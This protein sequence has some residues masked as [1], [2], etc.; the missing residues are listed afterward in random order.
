MFDEHLLLYTLEYLD[1]V[2]LIQKK[3]VSKDW[4]RLCTLTI[5]SKCHG[6]LLR[7]TSND[8]RQKQSFQSTEEIWSAV[9]KYHG[10]YGYTRE[11]TFT[12]PNPND[13]E[14]VVSTYGIIDQWDVSNITIFSHLFFHMVEF[15]EDI[16]SWDVSNAMSMQ[17]MFSRAKSFNQDLSSWNTPNVTTM[18]SMFE[19]A[20]SFNQDVSSW[21]TSNVTIME[22]MFEGA[23][24]F[25]QDL[26]SW[27]T[28]KVTTM[29][30]MFA[31]AESFNQDVSTWNTSNVTY[32]NC[33]FCG[34]KS[35]NRGVSSWDTSNVKDM[36]FMFCNAISF[37]QNLFQ[38]VCNVREMYKMFCRA[39]A[40]DKLD[41]ISS[42]DTSNVALCTGMFRNC[43]SFDP[44]KLFWYHSDMTL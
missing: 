26:S 27:N 16:S 6:G 12:P 10:T 9:E 43:M 34:A 33:M 19:G 15:N 42:W 1:T 30:S 40:F 29:E 17:C 7:N 5:K 23:E 21:N 41:T 4:K 38:D 37:N 20:A 39:T 3:C 18:E 14:D 32:M 25:N 28:S 22:S 31:G 36:S 35:F 13:L 24:S 2:S 44:T 8:S 11:R